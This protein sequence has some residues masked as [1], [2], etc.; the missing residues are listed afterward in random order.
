MIAGA[1]QLRHFMRTPREHLMVGDRA[2][3]LL[4][5]V[6]KKARL[7]E[8]GIVPADLDDRR[9]AAAATFHADTSRTS[10]GRRSCEPP[11]RGSGEESTVGRTRH[12]AGGPR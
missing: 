10:D 8:P 3:H 12:C 11:A 7:A 5:A 6:A 4:A 9:G 1:R 2:N